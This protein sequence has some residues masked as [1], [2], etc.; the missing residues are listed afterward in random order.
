MRTIKLWTLVVAACALTACGGASS[1]LS[2][3]GVTNPG[4]GNTGGNT[5]GPPSGS[6]TNAV[7]VGTSSFS[8]GNISVAAGSTVT[9]TWDSCGSDPYGYGTACISH[10]ITF[11]D[12][13]GLSSGAQSQGSFSRTFATAGTF[14]YHCS[15]HGT[16]MSGQVVVQ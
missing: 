6:A 12:G 16:A 11:D 10:D 5:G 7:T 3:G 1:D 8:P 2:G 15:I 14:K 9:W 4:G 13:S